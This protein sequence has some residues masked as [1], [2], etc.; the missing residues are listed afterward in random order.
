VIAE[1]PANLISRPYRGLSVQDVTVD[2]THAALNEWITGRDVYRRTEFMLAR[3]DGRA[4]LLALEKTPGPDLFRPVLS[5]RVLASADQVVLIDDPGT[6]VG[7]A[8]AL[9]GIA[10][11]HRSPGAIAYVVTGRYRHVNFILRPEP[12][13]LFVDEVVPPHPPKLVDMVHQAIRFDEDLPPPPRARSQPADL[14][15]DADADPPAIELPAALPRCRHA[16]GRRRN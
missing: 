12:V 14:A 3:R 1:P 2:L 6:D 4:A 5:A 8:T 9:S 10:G 16:R 15:A 11:R 13:V 7:N